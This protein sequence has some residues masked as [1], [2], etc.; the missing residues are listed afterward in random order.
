MQQIVRPGSTETN[1]IRTQ[2]VQSVHSTQ[3]I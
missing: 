2:Q 1:K 3:Q